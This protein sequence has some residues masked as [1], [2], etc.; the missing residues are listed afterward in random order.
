MSGIRKIQQLRNN[1]QRPQIMQTS[2]PSQELYLKDGDQ[3]FLQS[4]ATGNDNDVYFDQVQMYTWE[5][6][7]GGLNN[8]LCHD[9]VDDSVVPVDVSPSQ[10][11]AFWTYVFDL[12][13]S[14]LTERGREAGWEP[15]ED[16]TGKQI[17]KENVNDFKIIHL[18]Y[19]R[20]SY[21]FNQLTD[22]YNDWG[23]LDKGVIR[24]K[25]TGAGMQDTSY[26]IAPTT[27]ELK[28]PTPDNALP[29]IEEYFLERYSELWSPD[30]AS[31]SAP[32]SAKPSEADIKELF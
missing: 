20:N 31:S 16:P 12:Y 24:L 3:I 9:R 11:F 23:S 32:T 18:S 2:T 30:N 15:I 28:A 13:H 29:S 10:K 25:R 5:R 6:E 17:Y 8:L 27:R 22:I 14:T 19:G 7:G 4:V 1:L 26:T 21:V